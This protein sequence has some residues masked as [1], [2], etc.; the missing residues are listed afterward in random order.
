MIDIY[1]ALKGEVRDG[2]S[3]F[4]TGT[5]LYALVFIT[6]AKKVLDLGTGH[7]FSML[8][9]GIAMKELYT[10]PFPVRDQHKDCRPD[11][12]PEEYQEFEK[13]EKPLLITVD[14]GF[15]PQVPA[16]IER[17]QLQDI[18]VY[19]NEDIFN[20]SFVSFASQYKYDIIFFDATKSEKEIDTYLPMA[21]KGGYAVFHDYYG[22]GVSEHIKKL[23]YPGMLFDTMFQS[24]WICRL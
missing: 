18:V 3:E 13:V 11:I 10:N 5:F 17:Y 8:A 7:G 1:E 23:K 9:M 12:S 2:A 20:E 21:R 24:F 15:N 22:S 16:L 4:S 19:V 6:R 14:C